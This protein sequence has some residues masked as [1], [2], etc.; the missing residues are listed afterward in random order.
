M[1]PSTA[2]MQAGMLGH[3]PRVTHRCVSWPGKPS[4]LIETKASAAQV[5]KRKLRV[6]V[7]PEFML[8]R[9]LLYASLLCVKLRAG[10]ESWPLKKQSRTKY[11]QI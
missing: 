6:I 1:Y 3:N 8:I 5:S 9:T 4:Q 7:T 2:T 11:L 10:R